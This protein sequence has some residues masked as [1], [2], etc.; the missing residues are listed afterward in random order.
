MEPESTD[1]KIN[2]EPEKTDVEDKYKLAFLQIDKRL[3]NL[4]LALGEL[5]EK[6]K[7]LKVIDSETANTIQE[8]LEDLE[9]LIMVEN[10]GGVELKKTL[11]GINSQIDELSKKTAILPPEEYQKIEASLLQKID[12]KIST[13][14]SSPSTLQEEV[15][16]LNERIK[17]LETDVVQK[18]VSEVADLRNEMSKEIRDVKD[19][20]SGLG[21]IKPDID[22]KFLSSRLNSLKE[23]VEYLLNRKTEIDMRMENL[24]KMLAQLALKAEQTPVEKPSIEIPSSIEQRISSLEDKVGLL[25]DKLRTRE[26]DE[27]KREVPMALNM[28]INELLDKIVNLESRLRAVE[29][30]IQKSTKIEPVIV[31]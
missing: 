22:I 9:D 7:N 25:A 6:I 18:I 15:G 29:G 3:I 27:G 24:Q 10:L 31:E 12:E 4:E 17:V 13:L 14:P 19:R 23:N 1:F 26:I 11:E 30:G 2:Q 28:Q 20:V 5:N 16:R 21:T 8:R